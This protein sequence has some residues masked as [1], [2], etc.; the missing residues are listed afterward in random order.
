MVRSYYN[1][2]MYT[3]PEKGLRNAVKWVLKHLF[4][5]LWVLKHLLNLERFSLHAKNGV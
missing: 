1:S 4:K 5:L 2:F 3:A